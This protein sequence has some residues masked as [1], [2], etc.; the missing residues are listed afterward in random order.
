MNL[1][2]RTE[3][4]GTRPIDPSACFMIISEPSSCETSK[5]ATFSTGLSTSDGDM[6]LKSALR[7]QFIKQELSNYWSA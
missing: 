7:M 6:M 3:A 4:V 5:L 1:P 2:P